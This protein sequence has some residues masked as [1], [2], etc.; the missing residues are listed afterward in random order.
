M[1]VVSRSV[2]IDFHFGSQLALDNVVQAFGAA[3]AIPVT[4]GLVTYHSDSM[5]DWTDAPADELETILTLL[6]RQSMQGE[7]VGIE[8]NWP[9]VVGG[10]VGLLQ[11]RRVVTFILSADCRRLVDSAPFADMGWYLNTLVPALVPLGLVG[12]VTTDGYL[13]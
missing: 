2:D 10:N 13:D 7:P 5:Y 11:G 9:G 1:R 8:V 12:V 4:H 6:A 3:G